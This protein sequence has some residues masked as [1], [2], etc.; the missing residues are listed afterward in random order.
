MD[1][2]SSVDEM[3]KTGHYEKW[4]TDF[5]LVKEMGIRYLRYGPPYYKVTWHPAN[6]TGPL[7]IWLSTG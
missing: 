4:E 5:P 2:S 6:M 1:Q 3:A 7:P